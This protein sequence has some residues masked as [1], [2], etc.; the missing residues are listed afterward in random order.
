M[1]FDGLIIGVTGNVL[2][3]DQVYFME[4]GANA[5]LSKPLDVDQLCAILSENSQKT[6][7]EEAGSASVATAIAENDDD[8][9]STWTPFLAE[10]VEEKLDTLESSVAEGQ[11]W[12]DTA[13]ASELSP[14]LSLSS[15]RYHSLDH[16]RSWEKTTHTTVSNS[17]SRVPTRRQTAPELPDDPPS[18]NER[19]NDQAVN[20]RRALAME[21]ASILSATTAEA[22]MGPLANIIDD[23]PT[24]PQSAASRRDD[25]QV[26]RNSIVELAMGAVAEASYQAM[27]NT[28]SRRVAPNSP[29]TDVGE[30]HRAIGPVGLRDFALGDEDVSVERSYLRRLR[31]YASLSLWWSSILG[32]RSRAA[33]RSSDRVFGSD[34]L[35][36]EGDNR[37]DVIEEEH[38]HHA[39]RCV[40]LSF[41]STRRSGALKSGTGNC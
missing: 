27:R 13:L 5:V 1:G 16:Q 31:S 17:R 10:N 33:I 6:K 3:D 22:M 38:G 2:H 40:P 14:G 29:L 7:Q 18:I 35:P 24:S 15:P 8:A 20:E 34:P 23:R 12:C 30:I 37:D 36:I 41:L 26:R 32:R 39:S 25:Q 11:R 4:Q 28:R 9:T 21:V 19:R